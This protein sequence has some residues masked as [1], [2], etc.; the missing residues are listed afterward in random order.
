MDAPRGNTGTPGTRPKSAETGGAFRI[1]GGLALLRVLFLLVLL[2][3]LWAVCGCVVARDSQG[4]RVWVVA[5]KAESLVVS[6]AATGR[7]LLACGKLDQVQGARH[8]SQGV[9]TVAGVAVAGWVGAAE[10]AARKAADLGAQETARHAAT[11]AGATEARRLSTVGAAVPALTNP[12][13]TNV[14]AVAP[15]LKR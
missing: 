12:E 9:S 2:A 15:L 13:A 11:V 1:Y 4:R 3:V 14:G 8:I 7:P 10:I 5:N 6:D